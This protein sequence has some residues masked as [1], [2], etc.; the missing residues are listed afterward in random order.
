MEVIGVSIGFIFIN[1]ILMEMLQGRKIMI[2][3]NA[4]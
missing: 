2:H 3:R 4:S 1:L